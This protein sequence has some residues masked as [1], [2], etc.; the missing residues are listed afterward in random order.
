MRNQEMRKVVMDK[1]GVWCGSSR[2][3]QQ[4]LLLVRLRRRPAS[5]VQ[6]LELLERWRRRA[7]RS[8]EH[9]S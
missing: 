9:M 3:K 1:L 8:D 2:V 7:R 5:R 4:L 6:V